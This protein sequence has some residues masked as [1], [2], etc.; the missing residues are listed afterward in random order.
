MVIPP[1]YDPAVVGAPRVREEFTGKANAEP[2]K[3]APVQTTLQSTEKSEIDAAFDTI[4]ELV[5]NTFGASRKD[6]KPEEITKP[7]PAQEQ[8]PQSDSN[9]PSPEEQIA[10]N[11]TDNENFQKHQRQVSGAAQNTGEMQS[12]AGAQA[13]NRQSAQD[14]KAKDRKK[15][16]QLAAYLAMLDNHIAAID[17]RLVEIGIRL[18]EIGERLDEIDQEMQELDVISAKLENGTLDPSDP[19]DAALMDKYGITEE[20]IKTGDAAIKVAQAQKDRANEKGDLEKERNDL[21]REK[22]DLDDEKTNA[23]RLRKE[24]E[25]AKTPEEEA[26]FVQK[27]KQNAQ[28]VDGRLEN[29]KASSD[30]QDRNV[31]MA[32]AKASSE[33][34]ITA[35]FTQDTVLKTNQ[36]YVGGELDFDGAP[37]KQA[38]NSDTISFAGAEGLFDSAPPMKENFET[39]ASG[40][41]TAPVQQADNKI[42]NVADINNPAMNGSMGG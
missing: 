20:D 37:S 39:A 3:A 26:A 11:R 12:A 28:T 10:K 31:R 18:D 40:I 4:V 2:A 7:A 36:V 33:N 14:G 23:Q 9:A 16:T 42:G 21:V 15:N 13:E 41:E 35:E 30:T 22:C 8:K 24:G 25:N 27:I 1:E 32:I 29:T 34:E 6:E 5:D 17:L 38:G 19:N